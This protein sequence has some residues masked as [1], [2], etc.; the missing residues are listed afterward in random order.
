[1]V[2]GVGGTV[3][4]WA[5]RSLDPA[6]T[7]RMGCT[8]GRHTGGPV[9]RVS[10]G[11][12]PSPPPP[13]P[14]AVWLHR[15]LPVCHPATANF[16]APMRTDRHAPRPWRSTGTDHA[17]GHSASERRLLRP[18]AFRARAPWAR[19]VGGLVAHR[20]AG[21]PASYRPGPFGRWHC[22]KVRSAT[23]RSTVRGVRTRTGTAQWD[24][25]G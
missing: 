18:T 12:P 19:R 8:L 6:A 3:V 20:A 1:V 2:E 4:C 16:L 14:A 5:P 9:E 11:H 17:S 10:P 15:A 13:P 25:R 24:S 23:G 7:V 21:L 22:R